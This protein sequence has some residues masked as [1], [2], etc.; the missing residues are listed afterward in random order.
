M[1]VN[2][3][4]LHFLTILVSVALHGGASLQRAGDHDLRFKEATMIGFILGTACLIG[5]IT[6]WTR[7]RHG[8]YAFAGGRHGYHRHRDGDARGW[9]WHGRG[10]RGM[11]L[12]SLLDR[13]DTTPGQEKA[14]KNALEEAREQLAMVRQP[15]EELG[16]DLGEA[17][18]RDGFDRAQVE[19]LFTR[20]EGRLK[21]AGATVIEAL[22]RVHAALEPE[23]RKQLGKIVSRW[24]TRGLRGF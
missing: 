22:E 7:H 3:H 6:I 18:Q 9:G 4:S 17:M 19:M 16:S 24:A 2:R 8:Y 5:L 1:D 23:Q 15:L 21:E 11:A 10:R 12:Y 14:I 20:A 13:L